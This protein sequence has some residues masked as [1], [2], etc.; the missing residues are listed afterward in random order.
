MLCDLGV[1]V[2][3]LPWSLI[4]SVPL[5]GAGR[6]V[7]LAMIALNAALLYLVFAMITPWAMRSRGSSAPRH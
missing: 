4:A 3:A 6:F 2:A 5:R 7:L 1:A